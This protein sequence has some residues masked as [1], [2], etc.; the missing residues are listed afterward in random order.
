M[1]KRP[2]KEVLGIS[3]VTLA[4]VGDAVF[5][6]FV[7]EKLALCHDFKSGEL[8]RRANK[9]VS[10]TAQA[11]MYDSLAG[12][13]SDD[14]EGVMRRARNTHVSQKAKSA[15]LDEYKKATALEALIGYLYLTGDSE[16]LGEI[17]NHCIKNNKETNE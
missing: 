10:A 9:A 1:E 15:S 3:S 8:T 11:G 16:R 14:E 12:T 4:F 6:L 7:R 13:L 5:S 17:L 2:Q